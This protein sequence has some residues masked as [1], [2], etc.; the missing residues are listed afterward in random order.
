MVSVKEYTIKI[1]NKKSI[2]IEVPGEVE[3]GVIRIEDYGAILPVM[4]DFSQPLTKTIDLLLVAEEEFVDIKL[5]DYEN[6]GYNRGHYILLK[7]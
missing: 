7:N 2:S 3:L 1:S 4:A 5:K 6:I